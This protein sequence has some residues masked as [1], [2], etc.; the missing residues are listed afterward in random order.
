MVGTGTR[1][2]GISANINQIGTSGSSGNN[3][4]NATTRRMKLGEDIMNGELKGVL[5]YR[6]G[7]KYGRF[8]KQDF[9]SPVTSGGHRL[10]EL[11]I[12]VAVKNGI[13]TKTNRGETYT[14]S[15]AILKYVLDDLTFHNDNSRTPVTLFRAK[16]NAIMHVAMGHA[17][18]SDTRIDLIKLLQRYKVM[19][20]SGRMKKFQTWNQ[21]HNGTI[22]K[23]R[24]TPINVVH[25][26]RNHT[27]ANTLRRMLGHPLPG[28]PNYIKS[29]YN[30]RNNG[31]VSNVSRNEVQNLTHMIGSINIKN[32]TNSRG[33]ILMPTM[34][35]GHKVKRLHSQNQGPQNNNNGVSIASVTMM[36]ESF[37]PESVGN[38]SIRQLLN[39]YHSE[40]NMET[41]RN[42]L[43]KI[44]EKVSGL[45]SITN[46]NQNLK[47]KSRIVLQL[48]NNKLK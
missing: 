48:V 45:Q 2:S 40:A 34:H 32:N 46:T 12:I 28:H 18:D 21:K 30:K 42:K 35:T 16:A 11:A 29:N 25:L 1:S 9:I 7:D 8:I 3:K 38:L 36:D 22:I 4:V 13:I 10:L 5:A 14:K 15:G 41:N 47:S 24:G 27:T 39:G 37:P 43:L 31:P 19:D 33:N 44:K 26:H 6:S 23:R 20:V 17:K